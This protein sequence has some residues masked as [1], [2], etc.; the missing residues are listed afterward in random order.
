MVFL[1][2]VKWAFSKT[3]DIGRS[4][5]EGLSTE[6]CCGRRNVHIKEESIL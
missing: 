4:A 1:Y 6:A 3:L 2:G 5:G